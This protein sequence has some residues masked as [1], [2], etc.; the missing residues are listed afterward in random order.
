[1][2]RRGYAKTLTDPDQS[3]AQLSLREHGLA[4]VAAADRVGERRVAG[5]QHGASGPMVLS[6]HGPIG[7]VEEHLIVRSVAIERRSSP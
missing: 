3:V 6:E 4:R 5:V 7:L 2:S 1:M